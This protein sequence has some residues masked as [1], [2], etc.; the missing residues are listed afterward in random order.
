MFKGIVALLLGIGVL[1][2][3]VAGNAHGQKQFSIGSLNTADQFTNSFEGF[4]ARMAEL[5]YRD[6]YNVRYQY[7]NSRGN[8]ELLK[9][10]AQKL[11]QDKLDL[12]VTSSTSATV[13]EAKA[14]EASRT[15]VLFLSAGNPQKLVKSFASSGSNLAGI[16]SGSLELMG[17]RL[18]LLREI[19]PKAI[20][21]AMP[22]DINSVNLAANSQEVAE[23]AAR[24][25]FKV[26]E[27][28]VASPEELDKLA[29]SI[30]R[31]NFDAIFTP[32]DS[33]VSNGIEGLAK[34]AMSERLPLISSLLVLVKKGALASYAADYAALGSQGAVLADKILRGARP[35]SLPIELP[36]KYKLAINLKTAKTIDL[37]I[38][39]EILLRADDVID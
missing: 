13:A 37:R 31:K 23:A 4:R 6:G 38:A 11:A 33:M 2:F 9:T 29:A 3:G 30:Q 5:G 20:R 12:I 35:A 7:Y 28:K 21:V 36:R 16:S 18:E 8:D 1:L 19:A 26:V 24:F 22:M 39:K 10:L 17:K 14:T 34:A 15:P 25:G 27:L 32:A